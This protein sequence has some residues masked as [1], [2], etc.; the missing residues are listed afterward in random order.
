MRYLVITT[1]AVPKPL[2]VPLI[3]TVFAIAAGAVVVDI[4]NNYRLGALVPDWAGAG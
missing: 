4:D 1:N 3:M 2:P